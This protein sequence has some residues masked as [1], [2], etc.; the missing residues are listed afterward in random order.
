MRVERIDILVVDDATGR[1]LP[2]V[3][4]QLT[5]GLSHSLPL[6]L[7]DKVSAETRVR[8]NPVSTA[9]VGH[10]AVAL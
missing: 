10:G 6:S 8:D 5:V 7:S 9:V 1:G 3:E 2:L 4:L